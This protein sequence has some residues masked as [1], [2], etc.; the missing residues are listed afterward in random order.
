M[1]WDYFQVYALTLGPSNFNFVSF[2]LSYPLIY[3]IFK[4]TPFI[5][6]PPILFSKYQ[7]DGI[8]S[9]DNPVISGPLRNSCYISYPSHVHCHPAMLMFSGPRFLYLIPFLSPA[10]CFAC[11]RY[12]EIK[13]GLICSHPIPICP[14]H[15]QV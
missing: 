8:Y 4:I 1:H 11:I 9:S 7:V 12:S 15:S 13:W 14:L 2:L 3:I 10:Q 5:F 6:F